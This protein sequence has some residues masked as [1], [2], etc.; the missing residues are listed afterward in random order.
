MVSEVATGKHRAHP[1]LVTNKN[2][3]R[4]RQPAQVGIQ[5]LTLVLRYL[6]IKLAQETLVTDL[7]LSKED[8]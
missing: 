7:Y 2:I 6:P 5:L 3:T 4:P 8:E 1:V